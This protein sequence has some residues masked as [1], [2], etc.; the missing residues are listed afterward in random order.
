MTDIKKDIKNKIE[1][2]NKAAK[3]YYVDGTEIVS[4]MEYDK[5][6]DELLNLEK[7]TGIV[8]ANSPTQNVGYEVLDV[9]PKENHP[10]RMLSLDKTK[11]ASALQSW[12]QEQQ[13]VLSWKI[14][15]LTIVLTYENGKLQKA[16]T[17][18]NGETGEVVTSNARRFQNV[19]GQISFKGNLVVRGEAYIKYSD[20]EA[21]NNEIPELDAKYKNPRNLCSGSVRQLN[22]QITS[23]RRV[24]FSAFSIASAEGVDFNNSVANQMNWLKDMGFEVVG[25][26]NVSAENIKEAVS[27]F[28]LE[29]ENMDIPSDGLVLVLD[30]II[31]GESLG[32]TAKFPR[33][34]IAFKW[35]DEVKETKLIEIEWSVSRT[36]LINPIAIFEDV[37]LEGTTVGRASVHNVSILRELELGY[38][39]IIK[40]YKAN[41][42]IP[43]IADNITR[44]NTVEIPDK[45]PVCAK[46]TIIKKDRDVEVLYCTNPDCPAKKIK[47][48]ALFVSRDAM[49]IESLSEATLDKFISRGIIKDCADL[50]KLRDKEEAIVNIS[51]YG[52]KSYDNLINSIENSRKTTVSRF[53]YSLGIP[54]IGVANAKLI[55]RATN[56]DWQAVKNLTFDQLIEIDGIGEVM[57]NLFVA[58]F[59]NNQNA[60]EIIALEKEVTFEEVKAYEPTLEGITF[61]ITGSVEQFANRNELKAEI[62]KR[63]G[64]VTGTVSAKTNYLINN[65]TTSNSSK[66]KKA[67]ELGIEIINEDEITKMMNIQ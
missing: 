12:L 38:E 33:N 29:I 48:F 44:S 54:S 42:I 58:Y 21:I 4:N 55:A 46:E 28:A 62:E 65:D 18:G 41:M 53:L 2:L 24:N 52:K 51:G 49:N 67:K 35:Q 64:K 7:E 37:E 1:Y 13:G 20:F 26:R 3:A 40:V 22:S 45:C 59:E 36:G 27:S 66:N 8:F 30:D 50:F 34:A 31:Y 25:Y 11:S 16:V 23:E 10:S 19:P 60:T 43:Q 61:V 5:V 47:K 6:Y 15:G 9:L 57:A 39:D 32:N 63:G 14:D 56:N 17:R